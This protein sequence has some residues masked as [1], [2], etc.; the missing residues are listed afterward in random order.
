MTSTKPPSEKAR[1]TRKP[2]RHFSALEK[3][4]AVLAVWTDRCK[5]SEVC[6]QLGINWITFHQWQKRAMEG[7][8]QALESRTNLSQGEVLSPRLQALLRP[9][10][11]PT[12]RLQQRLEAVQEK[13]N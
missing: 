3:T 1:K 11:L 6:R 10:T 8:V 5:P 12:A 7:I 9:A 13:A 4:Q 2:T